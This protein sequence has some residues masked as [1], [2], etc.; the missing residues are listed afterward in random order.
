[1]GRI[2]TDEQLD[3]ISA[4]YELARENPHLKPL[5]TKEL[6]QLKQNQLLLEKR[7]KNHGQK[8]S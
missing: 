4:Y 5:I 1:M 8:T 3:F 6:I 7:I 2:W